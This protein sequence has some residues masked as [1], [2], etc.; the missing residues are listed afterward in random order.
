MLMRPLA[1]WVICS[2]S[3]QFH[4]AVAK[5]SQTQSVVVGFCTKITKVSSA[6]N[7]K[8]D[9]KS[10]KRTKSTQNKST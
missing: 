10:R 5:W 3:N 8:G 6:G 1:N 9:P 7:C 4:T 2:V